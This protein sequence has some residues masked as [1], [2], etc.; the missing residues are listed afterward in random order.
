MRIF[1]NVKEGYIGDV[2][3]ELIAEHGNGGN[4]IN[5]RFLWGDE[6]VTSEPDHIKAILATEF[7]NF[8]KGALQHDCLKALMG[9]GIFGVD[10]DIWK[11]HRSLTRPFFNKERI[12]DFEIFHRNTDATI[13]KIKEAS[14]GGAALDIQDMAGRFTLDSTTE[15]LFGQCVDSVSAPLPLP[16]NHVEFGIST[17]SDNNNRFARALAEV[18]AEISRRSHTMAIW[19]VFEIFKDRTKESMDF[20]HN[21]V[22]PFI[23]EALKRKEEMKD[24]IME[25]DGER[26]TLLDHMVD[27]TDDLEV[28]RDELINMLVAGRDTTTVTIACV[29]HLLSIHPEAFARARKEVLDMVG[30]TN[31]PTYDDLR[32][33]K[34]LRAVV[35]ETLRLFP[36]VPFNLRQSI[37]PTIWPSS[38]GTKLYIPAQTRCCY[39]VF[40]THRRQDLWGPDSLQFDPDRWLDGRLRKYLTP[41]PFI[42]VPFNA[43]PRICLGQQFAYNEL[44]FFLVRLLQNFDRAELVPEAFPLNARPRPHWKVG[45]GAFEKFC[46][47]VDI[48]LYSKGGMWMKLHPASNSDDV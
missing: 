24:M 7:T 13:A 5:V 43:G 32:E 9:N 29:M 39:A 44:S 2:W 28:I 22:E 16:A 48:T 35:N 1:Q 20:L 30:P 40:F 42:F 21:Y 8:E 23:V 34:Y 10:G 31:P 38:N 45:R 19:P 41:N 4:T 3:N 26:N 33:M 17:T 25:K 14:A 37:N 46:P 36:P 11:F 15:F 6:I 47:K 12:T 18:Q 27:M